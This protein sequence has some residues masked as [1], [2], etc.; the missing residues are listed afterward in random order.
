MLVVMPKS[1]TPPRGTKFLPGQNSR[2]HPITTLL[3]QGTAE[4]RAKA[5]KKIRAALDKTNGTMVDAAEIL[6]CS[7]WTIDSW[8]KKLDLS[9]YAAE[10]RRAHGVPGSRHVP[11]KGEKK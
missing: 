8:M 4:A 6:D 3:R 7:W 9:A 2:A 5:E 11:K 1:R 10:L